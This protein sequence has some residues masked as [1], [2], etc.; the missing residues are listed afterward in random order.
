MLQYLN[1]SPNV[2]M[3][4]LSAYK[5]L[6]S[7]QATIT[8]S[9]N[10]NIRCSYN[11]FI[12]IENPRS[13]HLNLIGRKS[14]ILAMIAETLWV[15]SGDDAVH[16]FLSFFLPRAV[17]FSDDNV[18]WRGAYG[19][20]LYMYNQL[21]DMVS[22]FKQEGLETRRSL[23]SIY[24]PELDTTESLKEVYGLDNTKDR[25][26]NNMIHCFVTPDKKLHMNLTQRSGDIIWGLGSI[27]FFEFTF[28]QEMVAFYVSKL[29]GEDIELGEYNHSV[30][31]MHL[32]DFTSKQAID[33]INSD[34]QPFLHDQSNKRMI[35]P[36]NNID[37]AREFFIEVV[38][39]LT[40]MI[41]SPVDGDEGMI[42]I[43]DL[44]LRHDIPKFDNMLYD[45]VY[46]VMAQIIG[47]NSGLNHEF[48]CSFIEPTLLN[49]ITN[50]SFTK[51]GVKCE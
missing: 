7:D 3:A 10:G 34:V 48:D 21:Q 29:V 50:S 37:D 18:T 22:V 47:K 46:V 51:F 35:F 9:R 12:S 13:R 2:N 14:N 44:F 5:H 27:N 40:D 30:I 25:P 32:Y 16:P 19:P 45:Y 26:C 38:S 36:G 49:A 28:L 4:V 24:L 15:L 6:L 17:D 1:K 39:V 33:V 42:I 31:N 20:R 8:T 23:L 41:Q 43:N 11:N